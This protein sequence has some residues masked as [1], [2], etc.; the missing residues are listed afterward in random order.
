MLG[1]ND[2]ITSYEVCRTVPFK[3]IGNEEIVE[4]YTNKGIITFLLDGRSAPLTVGNFL[5]L[6]NKGLYNETTFHGAIKEPIPF[7][8]KGGMLNYKSSDNKNISYAKDNY[9]NPINGQVRFIPIEIKLENEESP[10]Y[11]KSIVDANQ[12]SNIKL[13]HQK[14]SISMARS[15]NI[16]SASSQF[17]ISLKL[18]EVLDGR[19]AVFGQI[20]KGM[21][22]LDVLEEG[23]QIYKVVHLNN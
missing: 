3:C 20:I 13:K 5:D 6:V 1:C 14:G 9:I 11:G 15:E 7:V 21:K 4:I 18:L 23:D 22:V 2:K 19:Y 17:F 16:N 8:I 12:I 10:R